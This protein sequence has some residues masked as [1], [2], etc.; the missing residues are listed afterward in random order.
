[1]PSPRGIIGGVSTHMQ[2]QMRRTSKFMGGLQD[3]PPGTERVSPQ[4]E[5]VLWGKLADTPAPE[6]Q[7]L[8]EA[9]A[10]RAGHT[11]DEERPCELCRFI[12]KMATKAQT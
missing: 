6:R 9:M 12:A 8:M 4:R 10:G 11:P 1:M 2:E 3:G 5:N 7:A